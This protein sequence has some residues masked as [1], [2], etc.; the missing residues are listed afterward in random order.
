MADVVAL[1]WEVL[2]WRRLKLRLIRLHGLQALN[3]HLVS[4]KLDYNLYKKLF[5]DELATILQDNGA[6]DAADLARKCADNESAAVDEVNRILDRIGRH[7]DDILDGAQAQKA[8]EL[9]HAY[10]QG[11]PDAVELIP[12]LLAEEGLTIE[13]LLVQALADDLDYIERIERLITVAESR[14]NASLREIDRRR[15][16]LGEALRRSV[17][18]VEGREFEVIEMVPAEGKRALDQRSQD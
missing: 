3:L 11:E 14:R 8:K 17:R 15:A 1:E 5:T 9:A 4:N 2:R 12:K 18:E 6:K 16:V 7:L 10:F 13:S